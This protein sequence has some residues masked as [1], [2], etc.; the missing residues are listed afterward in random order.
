[1]STISSS[2]QPGDAEAH[3]ASEYLAELYG[4][5]A[6]GE[7]RW[8]GGRLVS[9]YAVGDSVNVAFPDGHRRCVVIEVLTDTTY[10]VVHHRPGGG[11]EHY[12]IDVDAIAAF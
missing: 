11:R 2:V 3:A 7:G 12:A 5:P 10:H 6:Q 9:T 1:M 8:V 4:S